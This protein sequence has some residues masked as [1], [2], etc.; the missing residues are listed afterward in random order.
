MYTNQL[1]SRLAVEERNRVELWASGTKFL[2]NSADENADLSFVFEVVKSN[3]TI[4]LILTDDEMNIIS[5][6]NFDD[7]LSKDVEYQ[8]K[9]LS[10]ILGHNEPIEINLIGSSKKILKTL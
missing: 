9:Q 6:R 3:N 8:K 1:V 5:I 2:A 4:P 7:E 10:K